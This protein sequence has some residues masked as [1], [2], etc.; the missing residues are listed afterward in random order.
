MISFSRSSYYRWLVTFLLRTDQIDRA[1]SYVAQWR[2]DLQDASPV[3]HEIVSLG[4]AESTIAGRRG[5]HSTALAHAQSAAARVS[6]REPNRSR[7]KAFCVLIESAVAAGEI[8]MAGRYVTKLDDWGEIEV[9][10]ERADVCRVKGLFDRARQEEEPP[11]K[12]GIRD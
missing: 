1:N 12:P 3:L 10:E 7:L 4:C 5:Q 2:E 6:S 9:G 11:D 8:E